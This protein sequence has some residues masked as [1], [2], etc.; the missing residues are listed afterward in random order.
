LIISFPARNATNLIKDYK[1]L[2]YGEW[3]I[4]KNRILTLIL[5]SALLLLLF[6]GIAP[7]Y[8]AYGDMPRKS[9]AVVLFVGPGFE[10]RQEEA[11]NL[12]NELR[13]KLL[14][15]P[16]YNVAMP[17]DGKRISRIRP[18]TDAEY[19]A[20]KAKTKK[21]F[22]L[23]YENTHVEVMETKRLMDANNVRSAIF[24]SS[25]YHMRRIKLISDSVFEPKR[26]TVLFV[27]SRN[28]KAALRQWPTSVKEVSMQ[29]SEYVKIVWYV[30]YRPF[31]GV[32]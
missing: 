2:C 22:K 11:C 24:V 32:T 1:I 16:A 5:S 3:H 28:E 21:D 7:S 18:I 31:A 20:F 17:V 19:R 27:P 15:I 9:D 29:L 10:A 4:L 6:A 13:P 14:I 26:Y 12:I 8:L 23:W 30:L 25:P